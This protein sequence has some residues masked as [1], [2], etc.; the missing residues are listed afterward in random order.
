MAVKDIFKKV[1]KGLG[2]K[3]LSDK[4]EINERLK[5]AQNRLDLAMNEHKN[6]KIKASEWDD[7]YNNAREIKPLPISTVSDKYNRS[8][9]QQA[10]QVVNITYQ[11][12]ESQIDA[13]IPMP[14]V[15]AIEEEDFIEKRLMVEGMLSYISQGPELQRVNTENERIVKK[16]GLCVY[17]IG[18]NPDIRKHNWHGEI[19][20]TN[21]H[22]INLVPQPG[23]HRIQDM[24]YFFHIENR[25]ISYIVRRYGKDEPEKL[26][27][28][29]EKSSAKY[30]DLENLGT[31]ERDNLNSELR[32]VVEMWYR[33][34]DGDVCKYTWCD[35]IEL[36]H[37]PKFYYKRDAEGNLIEVE[38]IEIEDEETGEMKV[39]EV[40]AYIPTR[41]PFVIQ[42][43]VPKEKSFLGKSD[44]EIISDQQ[45]GIKKIL[46]MNEEKQIM[47]TTKII[48]RQGSGLKEKLTNATSQVLETDDPVGDVK[49]VDMKTHDTQLIETYNIY[50]QAAKDA[51]GVTEA[52]QGRAEFSNLSGR[53]IELLAQNSAS[54][55]DVK[56]SE[57]DIAY[58][59]LYQILYDF[60]MA[61]Y[62]EPR[63]F[64]VKG[65][66]N[67]PEFGYFDK[68]KLVKQDITGEYYWPEFDIHISTELGLPKT[69][70]FVLTTATEAIQYGALDPLGYWTILQSIG[71]PNASAILNMIQQQQVSPEEQA[72]MYIA[73]VLQT[74]ATM[75]P[76]ARE[77]FLQAPVENQLDM[78][79][80]V[81]GGGE[82]NEEEGY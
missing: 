30:T 46:S 43:N 6:F 56:K 22:P 18:Y 76:A 39:V 54:R 57:K 77:Q 29:L 67:L 16:N 71:F 4:M 53:A 62:D 78:L 20:I 63:P 81:I 1:V 45:E 70:E 69:K 79:F 75:E 33:D 49:V 27:D 15:D 50:V 68:G 23:V 7:Q 36:E 8:K 13:T 5:R 35:E 58:T 52:S 73:E 44:P 9:P 10:R 40:P 48:T 3:G 66:S 24:D 61:Y 38:E 60:L 72:E 37:V 14:A 17:K 55:M 26:K 42:Y 11:L 32:S 28:A 74:L 47:G 2:M 65:I 31:L 41:Y 59:E 21:P 19:E 64:R 80:Q 12:V 82:Q 34:E 51:L 25:S